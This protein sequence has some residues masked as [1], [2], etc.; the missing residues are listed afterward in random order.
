MREY[1]AYGSN[2]GQAAMARTCPGH[3][4]LGCA[5]LPGYRL[6]FTRRSVRTGTGVAD[7]V[8]DPAREVWGALY[9]IGDEDLVALDRKEGAGWAYER[10]EMHVHTDDGAEHEVLVYVV[11]SKATEQVPPSAEY[12]RRVVEAARER[13]LPDV[14]I[15]ALSG[16]L[17]ALGVQVARL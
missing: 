10:R 8:V 9:G 4:Y 7:V 15:E 16:S 12:G 17:A 1:F 2:M 13:G 3:R 6:A 11:I 5:R 14:Y